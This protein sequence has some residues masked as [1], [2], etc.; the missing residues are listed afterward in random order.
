MVT[1]DDHPRGVVI[2]LD[3]AVYVSK[4]WGIPLNPPSSH[5]R[6]G[7]TPFMALDLLQPPKIGE[8]I[9]LFPTFHLPRYDLESFIWVFLWLIHKDYT[10]D[11]E[12]TDQREDEESVYEQWRGPTYSK[13]WVQKLGFVLG[14]STDGV[15]RRFESLKPLAL[16]LLEFLGDMQHAYRSIKLDHPDLSRRLVWSGQQDPFAAWFTDVGG[17]MT[18]EKVTAIFIHHLDRPHHDL[19]DSL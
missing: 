11:P 10:N 14:R 1:I 7:T 12:G 4:E 15:Q 16:D 19:Y 17:H 9:S 5:H 2:D 6:T 3:I 8:A 18:Y 13:A